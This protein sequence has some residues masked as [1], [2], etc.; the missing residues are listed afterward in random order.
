MEG[1]AS[2]NGTFTRY[3]VRYDSGINGWKVPM[4]YAQVIFCT[5]ADKL[6]EWPMS[7]STKMFAD[8]LV[9]IVTLSVIIIIIFIA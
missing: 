3:T 2:V 8:R 6:F 4:K 7:T 1:N 9:Q 5:T